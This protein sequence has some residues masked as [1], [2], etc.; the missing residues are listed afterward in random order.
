[1]TVLVSL[2]SASVVSEWLLKY[3]GIL[4]GAIA[5]LFG[6]YSAHKTGRRWTYITVVG[7]L[8]GMMWAILSSNRADKEETDQMNNSIQQIDEY[9]R[10]QSNGLYGKIAELLG[11]SSDRVASVT[12]QQV[13]ALGTA[14]VDANK[15]LASVTQE[16]HDVL[17]IWVFPHAQSQV[18]FA[19][20]R[21]SLG[22]LAS[23]VSS[24]P[25]QEQV[26]LTN[27]VW[28]GGG[29]TLDEAKAAALIVTSAGLQ[30]RQICPATK[31][32]VKNLIQVG[33]SKIAQSL[34]ILAAD[35]IQSTQLPICTA[36]SPSSQ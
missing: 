1:M 12:P 4:T 8:G 9:V 7:I 25:N 24:P 20:V 19:V 16:R 5:A 33:G 28:Y 15:L 6:L 22:R 3:G 30:I 31:L 23:T 17:T 18:N 32:K 27:S 21:Q 34:P 14:G 26:A 29:A 13:A 36:N 10:G 11:V 35:A 2:G